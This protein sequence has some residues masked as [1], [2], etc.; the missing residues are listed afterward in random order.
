MSRGDDLLPGPRETV[1]EASAWLRAN[2]GEH[3]FAANRFSTTVTAI[4]FIDELYKSGATH[5]CI[6]NAVMLP[7][8]DWTLYADTLL[9]GMPEDHAQRSRL[10][11]LM[12]HVGKADDDGG[13]VHLLIDFGQ[14]EVRL[15]SD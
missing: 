6:D 7:N 3:A 5:V 12:K 1:A 9:V 2:W 13:D 4:T 15:S 14:K 10:F 11:D 8:H